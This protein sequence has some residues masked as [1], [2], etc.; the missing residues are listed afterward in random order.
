MTYQVA[1]PGDNYVNEHGALLVS[2]YVTEDDI[3]VVMDYK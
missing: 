3:P 2:N 1:D